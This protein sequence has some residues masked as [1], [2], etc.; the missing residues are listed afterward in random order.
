[1]PLATPDV[2]RA[3]DRLGL[4]RSAA[5]LLE[6]RERLREGLLPELLVNDLEPA[7]RSLCPAIDP[8]LEALRAAGADHAFV[9]GS[10]PTTIGLWWGGEE[11]RTAALAAAEALRERF[12]AA[13]AAAPVGPDFAAV[14]AVRDNGAAH[15]Q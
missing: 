2:F 10:G 3:A 4:G 12:P 11:A 5:E 15:E 8:A 7:A 6:L 14:G 13:V 9:S 1:V